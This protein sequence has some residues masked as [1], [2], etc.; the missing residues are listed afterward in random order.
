LNADL[1]SYTASSDR[2]I[3]LVY[4]NL[5]ARVFDIR[6]VRQAILIAYQLRYTPQVLSKYSRATEARRLQIQQRI[7]QEVRDFYHQTLF[8]G[9]AFEFHL[10]TNHPLRNSSRGLPRL[11]FLRSQFRRTR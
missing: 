5:L 2:E 7:D 4:F 10:P 6:T 11:S 3:A 8:L 9:D 1:S